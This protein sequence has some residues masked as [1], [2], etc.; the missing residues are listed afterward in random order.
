MRIVSFQ[1]FITL[2]E[3]TLYCRNADGS[4]GEMEVKHTQLSDG[5][6]SYKLLSPVAFVNDDDG[7]DSYFNTMQ[8]SLEDGSDIEMD[9]TAVYVNS[10]ADDFSGMKAASGE[11]TFAVFSKP[12]IVDMLVHLSKLI[13]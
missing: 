10:D 5:D 11:Y 1:E 7:E 13:K 9:F 6:W 2:P 12:D 8:R 4:F 3:G